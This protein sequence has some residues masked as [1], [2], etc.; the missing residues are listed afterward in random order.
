MMND[1]FQ[2]AEVKLQAKKRARGKMVAK[3]TTK[4]SKKTVPKKAKAKVRPANGKGSYSARDIEVLEGLEPIR[5]RPGM[6]IGGTDE[7]A[8]HHLAAKTAE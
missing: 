6:Y 5:R 1:L 2:Q 8:L 4:E 7:R 3:Q